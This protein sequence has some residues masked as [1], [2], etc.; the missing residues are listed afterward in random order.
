MTKITH[1]WWMVTAPPYDQLTLS[2]IAQEYISDSIASQWP[3]AFSAH[4]HILLLIDVV[5]KG[6]ER[7]TPKL[8]GK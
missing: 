6:E 5:C 2:S 1:A 3:L 8:M 4:M 7:S